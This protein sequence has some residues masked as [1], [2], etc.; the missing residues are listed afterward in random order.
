M[1]NDKFLSTG[2]FAKICNVTKQTL[3]HYD[4]IGLLQP[5]HKSDNGYRYYSYQQLEMM[6][7]IDSLKEIGMS[8]NEI[9]QFIGMTTPELMI[10]TF[11]EK[12]L[13]L[14]EKI[15][16][17]LRIQKV[18]EKKIAITEQA[19]RLDFSQISI[20]QG[21]EHYL[22]LSDS[23][24]YCTNQQYAQSVTK[25]YYTCIENQLN[26]GDS[27][28]VM[29]HREQLMQHDFINYS[30]LF[31]KVP[32]TDKVPLYKKEKG[33]QVVGYHIGHYDHVG[34]TYTKMLDYMAAKQLQMKNYS[35]EEYIL[36]G[37]SVQGIE[38]YVTKITIPVM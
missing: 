16:S 31:A 27:I 30:Y 7:V 1:D 8:L 15:A 21:N 12:S 32:F 28:G 2:D 11:K 37:V 25:L 34:Q 24:L 36:D 38:Q 29:V 26:E 13:L 18:I 20:E 6:Y 5:H 35:F 22:C 14:S 10:E 9:K 33:L 4:E 23:M 19:L 17:L 3:F